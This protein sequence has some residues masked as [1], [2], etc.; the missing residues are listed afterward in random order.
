ML[1]SR[2]LTNR[3]NTSL[4]LIYFLALLSCLSIGNAWSQPYGAPITLN[5]IADCAMW[6]EARS[7]NRAVPLEHSLQGYLNGIATGAG[8]DV[9]TANGVRTS[10]EQA[11][12]FID[13]YC[14]KNPLKTIWDGGFDLANEKTN[15]ALINQLKSQLKQKK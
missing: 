15:N 10:K 7:T 4:S 2:V 14:Q 8:I 3:F 13:N 12:L 5:G 9:W 1:I 6:I 11:F